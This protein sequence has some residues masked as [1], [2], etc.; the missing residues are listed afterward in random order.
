MRANSSV[1]PDP[2]NFPSMLGSNAN[3]LP[4]GV[5]F[6]PSGLDASPGRKPGAQFSVNGQGGPLVSRTLIE[7][8]SPTIPPLTGVASK[9]TH[10]SAGTFD[11]DLPLTGSSGVECRSGGANGDYT[12]VFTFTNKLTTVGNVTVTSGTGSVNGSN[13]DIND[14]HNCIVNLTGV[15]NAQ[16]VTVSLTNISDSAGNFSP[17][18]AGSMGVLLGDA[19]ANGAVSNSDVALV[20]AQ[21]AAPVTSS[22]FRDDVNVNGL[23]SNTDVS[24]TKAQVGAQLP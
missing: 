3:P 19:N 17:A 10:G 23:I 7:N 8:Y 11:I 9:M 22:N 13:I 21:V 16:V 24:I 4:P 12:L 5:P 14:A 20:K 6:P 1:L 18:L 2:R 15:T